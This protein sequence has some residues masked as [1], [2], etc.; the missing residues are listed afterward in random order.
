MTKASE[1]IIKKA[2]LLDRL[3]SHIGS[4]SEQSYRIAFPDKEFSA[5]PLFYLAD[6]YFGDIYDT[7][8]ET[9]DIAFKKSSVNGTKI[10]TLVSVLERETAWTNIFAFNA[11]VEAVNNLEIQADAVVPYSSED[12]AFGL[13]NLGGIEGALT[14]PIKTQVLAYIK[15]SLLD[16][17]W[18]IPPLFLMFK[19][20]EDMFEDVSRI[21]SVKNI[22]GHLTMKDIINLDSFDGLGIDG[23]LDMQNYLAR[24][25]AACVEIEKKFDKLMFD[26]TTAIRGE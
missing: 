21:E 12:I 15:A 11:F 5:F 9:I 18:D 3:K 26:W 16:D 14:L 20:I 19:N 10:K 17:G 24:N 6:K 13:I 8:N 2:Y 23:R 25:Q 7:E 1:D 4:L 22:F